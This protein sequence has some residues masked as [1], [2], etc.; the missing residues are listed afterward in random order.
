MTIIA[1]MTNLVH[2]CRG[3]PKKRLK[4]AAK[5]NTETS[6]VVAT[7]ASRMQFPHNEAVQQATHKK[8]SKNKAASSSQ[9][10]KT[11]EPAKTTST[12]DANTRYDLH[13]G[14]LFSMKCQHKH[15]NSS[16]LAQDLELDPM[17]QFQFKL[18]TLCLKQDLMKPL[19]LLPV[20]MVLMHV[21][22][23]L[24]PLL[25]LHL[26]V[27]FSLHQGERLRGRKS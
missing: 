17:S 8:R 24:M 20:L 3:L 22:M 9:G 12:S 10:K 26:L 14:S 18:S 16:V 21:L 2:L 11:K 4:K 15:P 19:L 1:D 23:V 13:F 5:A 6:I 7:S 25:L 27:Q